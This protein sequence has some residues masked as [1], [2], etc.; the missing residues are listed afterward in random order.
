MQRMGIG[1]PLAMFVVGTAAGLALPV[2]LDRWAD[3]FPVVRLLAFGRTKPLAS[4]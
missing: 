1:N 2:A 4:A 3:R